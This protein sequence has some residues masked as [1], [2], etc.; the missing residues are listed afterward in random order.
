MLKHRI[1]TNARACL[2]L[3]SGTC[4]YIL[5]P[6]GDAGGIATLKTSSSEVGIVSQAV[7][8]DAGMR[9]TD[10]PSLQNEVICRFWTS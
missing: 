3:C 10:K 5:Q 4:F 1:A 6:D 8:F 7:P 9:V 2:G